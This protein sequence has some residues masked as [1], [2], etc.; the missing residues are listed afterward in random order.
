MGGICNK[1]STSS[2]LPCHPERSETKSKDPFSFGM[3]F[4]F[5]IRVLRLAALAQNDTLFCFARITYKS[6]GGEP[7][8][9]SF[10]SYAAVP[11]GTGGYTDDSSGRA[12]PAVPDGFPAP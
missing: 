7:S 6:A 10:S 11:Y 4:T 2:K 1:K 3:V 9:L 12:G 5:G 8:A